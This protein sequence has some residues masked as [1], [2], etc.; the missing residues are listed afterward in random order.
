MLQ[1]AEKLSEALVL[2]IPNGGIPVAVSL[3]KTLRLSLK[4]LVCRKLQL[5]WNPEAGFGAI[6]PDGSLVINE[7]MVKALGLN[8]EA[9]RI[10]KLKALSEIKLKEKLFET[11]KKHSLKDK[12]VI[13]V[14]DGLAS[15]YT[16][17]AALKFA[18]KANSEKR[19]VAIPTASLG[20]LRLISDEAWKI[21]CANV[22]SDLLGFA[23]A[24]AYRNWY[25]VC[26]EEAAAWL[27]KLVHG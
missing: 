4:V 16:M 20:A 27:R 13:L 10:Q 15:G 14:D 26:D 6:A 5:P 11:V 25:D 22:R 8:N 19:V 3:A 12:T 23:V 18:K 2:A 9:I 24:D 17:L 21:Y 7:E 1:K